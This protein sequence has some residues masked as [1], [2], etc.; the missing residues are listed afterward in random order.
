MERLTALWALNEAGLGGILHAVNSPFTGIFVGSVAIVLITLIAYFAEKR[1]PAILKATTIVLIIKIMV[2]PHSP[3]LAYF[4]V[5][6]QA[7]AGAMLFA[8]L[9]NLRLAALL[10][11]MISMLETAFQRLLVVTII[12]GNSIWESIDIFFN[13]VAQQFGVMAAAANFRASLWLI[14]L[15]VGIHVFAGIFVGWLA[16]VLPREIRSALRHPVA[17][18]ATRAMTATLR[19]DT[20]NSR[21]PWW[22]RKPAKFML[23]LFIIAATSMLL[24]PVTNRYVKVLYVVLRVL[25]VLGFWVFVAA[26]LLMKLLQRFL[27]HKKSLYREEI[28]NALLLFPQFK[29][30]AKLLWPETADKKGWHR[31][32]E[33]LMAL[34]MFALTFDRATSPGENQPA[35]V[36]QTPEKLDVF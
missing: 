33:F 10:L 17:A 31:W 26:P 1:T 29:K 20:G 24:V 27:K 7:L 34:I 6:F 16:G 5:S 30:Y 8:L 13:Y 23:L 3:L 9:S 22:K 21:P 15:Y 28:E 12:Y 14:G 25:V 19:Y 32:K 36:E 11:G 18:S 4:A 2:S 35:L